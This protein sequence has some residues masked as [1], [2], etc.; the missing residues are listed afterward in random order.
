MVSNSDKKVMVH[1]QVIISTLHFN[2]DQLWHSNFPLG[3]VVV[4]SSLLMD[5]MSE[6]AFIGFHTSSNFKQNLEVPIG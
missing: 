3:D 5:Q 1:T 2:E 6:P 4:T